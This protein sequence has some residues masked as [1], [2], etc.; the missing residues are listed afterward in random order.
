MSMLYDRLLLS[1]NYQTT[2]VKE[3]LN[4]LI[5]EIVDLSS[6]ELKLTV[7]KQIDDV[8]LD[9]KILFPLGIIINE[10]LTN[11]LKYAFT[12]KDSGLI[13]VSLKEI[14]GEILLIV[15]DNGIGLPDRFEIDEQKGYGLMLIKMLAKQLGGNFTIGNHIGTKSTIKFSV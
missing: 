3:Y 4:N 8:Q 6:G 14:E 2:S 11:I 15:Q 10:L 12:G 1:D 5:E 13:E 7:K 9:A